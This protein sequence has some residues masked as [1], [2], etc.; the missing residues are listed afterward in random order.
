M[1]ENDLSSESKRLNL[2]KERAIKL[3]GGD[4]FSIEY[5]EESQRI[6]SAWERFVETGELEAG[7]VREV[8]ASSWKRS[9]EFGVDP[10]IK[11]IYQQVPDDEKERRLRNSHILCE[12][13]R[14]FL[15]NLFVSLTKMEF[16]IALMD[17][18]G[19]ILQVFYTGVIKEVM[20]EIGVVPGQFWTEEIMGTTAPT[21]A[22]STGEP[23]QVVGEE[24]WCE[25][26]KFATCVGAPIRGPEGNIA[27]ILDISSRYELA[28]DHIHT[29]GMV[30]AA[31][32]AI[33]TQLQL[34]LAADKLHISHGYLNAALQSI[35]DGL[36]ILN[37]HLEVVQINN[38]ARRLTGLNISQNLRRSVQNGM[39][40]EKISAFAHTQKGFSGTETICKNNSGTDKRVLIDAEPIK[41]SEKRYVGA[42][43]VLRELK[44]VSKLAQKIYGA[45]AIYTFDDIIGE[46]PEFRRCVEV[47]K[48]A[49]DSDAPI[50]ITG[51]S[52]TGKEMFAQ[53]V[54]NH[55]YRRDGPFIPLNC[56]A[57]PRDLFESELFG[58]DEGAFTGAKRGGNPGKFELADGGTIFLDEI[59]SMSLDMQAKLLR[60]IEE[61]R[62]SRLGGT[63]FIP[64]DVRIIAAS[65]KCLEECI[66]EGTFRD[67][68]YYRINVV[69]VNIPPLRERRNDIP[70][71]ASHFIKK[72][73]KLSSG[74]AR[75]PHAETLNTLRAYEWPGN[76]RELSN[77]AERLLAIGDGMESSR[78]TNSL[79]QNKRDNNEKE[80]KIEVAD[81]SDLESL[82]PHKLDEAEAL[83]IRESI[84]RNNGKITEAA[85][86]L[87][88]SRSTLYRKMAKYNIK[89]EK[90]VE[91]GPL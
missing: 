66:R 40:L 38:T 82:K 23:V 74:K 89:V 18:E 76:V 56:A 1:L 83:I 52:G 90:K 21:I 37:K 45:S 16:A 13:A 51:E 87:G 85:S 44:Q 54:H 80:N 78:K 88:I 9:R 10:N 15:E 55:S 25:I 46:D 91:K 86:D 7:V 33:E 27:G 32:K 77:W 60:V 3:F 36:I 63:S 64:I 8:I 11:D 43:L 72:Y 62:V 29:Y 19:F 71:L 70:L 69:D 5:E 12:V 49:S 68:L 67:D 84:A 6:R 48:Q 57:I 24:H 47:L 61:K 75:I 73:S 22:L 59:D 34:R 35:S 14:P 2:E 26:A 58:Y 31:A 53:A 50:I 20:D 79:E 41:D 65:R 39:M 17:N 42:V 4:N 28:G 81:V 30:L